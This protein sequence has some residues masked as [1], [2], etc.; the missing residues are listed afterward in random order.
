MKR[1]KNCCKASGITIEVATTLGRQMYDVMK[2]DPRSKMRGLKAPDSHS[3]I[4]GT[5]RLYTK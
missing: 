2:N 5:V 1:L 4:T 3:G